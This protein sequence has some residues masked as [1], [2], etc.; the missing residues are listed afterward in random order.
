MTMRCKISKCPT[1]KSSYQTYDDA[2]KCRNNHYPHQQ[3]WWFCT[4]GYGIRCDDRTQNSLEAE[5]R[6]HREI[7]C[8][9]NYCKI[10]DL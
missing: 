8:V 4:C 6:Q 9:G 1:C 10:G 2:I 3:D 5:I 7:A